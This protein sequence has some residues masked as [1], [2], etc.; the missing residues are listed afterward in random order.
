[1]PKISAEA[2]ESRREAIV[3]A[4]LACLARDGYEGTSMRT[5]AAAAGL[6]KGGLYAYFDS[7]EAILLEVARRYMEEQLSAFEPRPGERGLDQLHRMLDHYAQLE[8]L[9][10]RMA[11]QRAIMDL[12]S[13][14]SGL[15][16]VRR[17]MDARYERY[18]Q[19]VSGVIRRCQA[20]GSC[21]PDV[22]P[23]DLAGLILAARDGMMLESVKWSFPT[24]VDRL[25]ALLK[26]LVLTGLG[27]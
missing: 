18:L 4:A 20:E 3:G 11:R 1:M 7:K 8:Q 27:L 22:S 13:F 26:H 17:E 6:T 24:P 5:I 21:R 10:E 25:S 9:P 2:R 15:P 14:G 16:A 23:E 12:W 19:A